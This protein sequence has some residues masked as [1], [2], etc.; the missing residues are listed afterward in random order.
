MKK[1][2]RKTWKNVFFVAAHHPKLKKRF[3]GIFWFF[4]NLK[5]TPWC[6]K[7]RHYPWAE[8]SGIHFKSKE[9]TLKTWKN[10]WFPVF[11]IIERV[12]IK[13]IHRKDKKVKTVF[14]SITIP[15]YVFSKNKN[16]DSLKPQ[17]QWLMK[18]INFSKIKKFYTAKTLWK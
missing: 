3:L 4:W 9:K 1:T 16:T 10:V 15:N 12:F 13:G 5:P 7:V 18:T 6:S 2:W 11:F 17:V 14:P 8:M